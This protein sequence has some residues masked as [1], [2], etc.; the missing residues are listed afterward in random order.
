[1]KEVWLWALSTEW[2]AFRPS[3]MTL[4]LF[5]GDVFH[6]H[7]AQA[8]DQECRAESPAS[9]L[10]V[11]LVRRLVDSQFLEHSRKLFVTDAASNHLGFYQLLRHMLPSLIRLCLLPTFGRQSLHHYPSAS[12]R[13]A[14]ISSGYSLMTIFSRIRPKHTHHH[15]TFSP[16]YF[17]EDKL[18]KKALQEA[19]L[20]RQTTVA[21]LAAD[22]NSLQILSDGGAK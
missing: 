8:R 17:S 15:Y 18:L 7:G 20:V 6:A 14:Q 2:A 1:M 22:H 16:G 5:K 13:P 19:P 3:Q 4:P 10:T 11:Y 9:D 12:K 21:F